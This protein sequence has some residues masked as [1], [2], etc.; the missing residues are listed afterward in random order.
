MTPA[1]A[2]EG[3][4][5]RDGGEGDPDLLEHAGLCGFGRLVGQH[6]GKGWV[7]EPMRGLLSRRERKLAFARKPAVYGL[8]VKPGLPTK[9][10]LCPPRGE[11]LG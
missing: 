8:T 1:R 2:G 10:G 9:L 3:G 6:G 4:G 11:P 7:A 5:G